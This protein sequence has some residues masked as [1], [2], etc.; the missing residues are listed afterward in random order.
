MEK[1]GSEKGQLMIAPDFDCWSLLAEIRKRGTATTAELAEHFGR[2]NREITGSLQY[3]KMKGKINHVQH[4][5]NGRLKAQSIP[6][7]WSAK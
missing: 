1:A 3:L 2:G 5:H 7:I 4:G 6:A